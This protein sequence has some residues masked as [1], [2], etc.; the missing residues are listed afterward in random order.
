MATRDLL[1]ISKKLDA[2]INARKELIA[3]GT[4]KDYSEYKQNVGY[5]EGLNRAVEIIDETEQEIA[6]GNR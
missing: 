5:L 6:G 4:I 2:E 1:I 3:S